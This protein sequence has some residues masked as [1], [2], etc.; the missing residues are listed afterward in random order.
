MKNYKDNEGNIISCFGCINIKNE[1]FPFS[2]YAA[3]CKEGLYINT[4]GCGWVQNEEEY[5]L[6]IYYCPVCGKQ[7]KEIK[8]Y[9]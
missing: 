6:R 5:Y 8:I 2:G 3:N 1:S 4:E 9:D 7:L